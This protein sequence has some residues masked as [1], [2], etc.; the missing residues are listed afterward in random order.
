ME[1]NPLK[2]L[3]ES[4]PATA[5]NPVSRLMICAGGSTLA[6]A[7]ANAARLGFRSKRRQA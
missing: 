4:Q 7:M 3:L 5:G 1:K 6:L 2:D